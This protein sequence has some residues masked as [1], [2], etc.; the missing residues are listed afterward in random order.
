MIPYSKSEKFINTF[1]SELQVFLML[2]D[3]VDPCRFSD[4]LS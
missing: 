2:E 3:L 1:F 4:A